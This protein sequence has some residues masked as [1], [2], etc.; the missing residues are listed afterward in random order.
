[1]TRRKYRYIAYTTNEY[2][3]RIH[4]TVHNTVRGAQ[5]TH[6]D[7]KDSWKGSARSDFDT[8]IL[9][10]AEFEEMETDKVIQ[11]DWGKRVFIHT[12]DLK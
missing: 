2:Q 1:M 10:W 3:K 6:G 5:R 9:D 4:F 8:T 11:V 12:Q 7:P